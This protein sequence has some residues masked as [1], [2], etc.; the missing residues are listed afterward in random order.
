MITSNLNTIMDCEFGKYKNEL[1]WEIAT[2][3]DFRGIL[4]SI[5]MSFYTYFGHYTYHYEYYREPNQ[6]ELIWVDVETPNE[7]WIWNQEVDRESTV[8]RIKSSYI[9]EVDKLVADNLSKTN[10]LAYKDL[11]LKKVILYTS[12]VFEDKRIES[13]FVIK[14]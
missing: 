11:L 5:E 6:E 1:N 9:Y 14:Y 4:G 7:G 12:T 10:M 8:N 2:L 13:I 3:K